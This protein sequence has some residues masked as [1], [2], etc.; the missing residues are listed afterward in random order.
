MKA[1]ILGVG[2]WAQENCLTQPTAARQRAPEG[3][4]VRFTLGFLPGV[5]DIVEGFELARGHGK[6]CDTKDEIRNLQ[7]LRIALSASRRSLAYA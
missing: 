2:G 1:F 6:K 7:P 3:A 5:E 4:F